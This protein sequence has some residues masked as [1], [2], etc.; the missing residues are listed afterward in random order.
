MLSLL[1]VRHVVLESKVTTTDK[2][3][4]QL[5][6]HTCVCVCEKEICSG[7]VYVCV[8]AFVGMYV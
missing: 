5:S 4:Q 8:R 1:V 6:G 2:R 7:C 3:S